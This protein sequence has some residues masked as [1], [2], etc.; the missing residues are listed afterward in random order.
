MKEKG[1]TIRLTTKR[2]NK[3]R[4]YAEHRDITITKAIEELID[5]IAFS[6]PEGRELQKKVD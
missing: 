4:L 3:I 2:N 1:I 5:T 6:P